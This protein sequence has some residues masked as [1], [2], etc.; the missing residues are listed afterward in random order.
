M[1]YC[2][3]MK[4]EKF[5]SFS[6]MMTCHF[7]YAKVTNISQT[8]PTE[9]HN[10]RKSK[11]LLAQIESESADVTT[12]V[13]HQFSANK[14]KWILQWAIEFGTCQRHPISC[15]FCTAVFSASVTSFRASWDLFVWIRETALLSKTIFPHLLGDFFNYNFCWL[16]FNQNIIQFLPF[17]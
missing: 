15:Y 16:T 1:Q 11:N 13:Q 2:S 12:A 17:R 4:Y 14:S 8:W 5:F 10:G 3:I 6:V 7:H 9:C